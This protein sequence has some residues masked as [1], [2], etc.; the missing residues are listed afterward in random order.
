[1]IRPSLLDRVKVTLSH[2]L[3]PMLLAQ[4]ALRTREREEAQ[5]QREQAYQVCP[6][7]SQLIATGRL[8]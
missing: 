4:V 7:L 3:N 1:M 2:T 8:S 5:R 6:S